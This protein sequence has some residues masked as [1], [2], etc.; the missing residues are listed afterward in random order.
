MQ[1]THD[2]PCE[3]VCTVW[4]GEEACVEEGGY[5]CVRR[6]CVVHKYVHNIYCECG[7][8]NIV[9]NYTATCESSRIQSPP[10]Q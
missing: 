6:L 9:A 5:I 10:L 3:C 1:S 8:V 2:G 7:R 4:G